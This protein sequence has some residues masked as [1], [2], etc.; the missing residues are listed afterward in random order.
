MPIEQHN[1]RER[2][3]MEKSRASL[4]YFNPLPIVEL[5]RNSMEEERM[6]ID[7]NGAQPLPENGRSNPLVT[8]SS[9]TS[10]AATSA[11]GDDQAQLS[12]TLGQV[13]GLA[14]QVSQ[15]PEVR[16][17]KVNALRQVVESG[18][19]QPSSSQVAGALFD[20]MMEAPAA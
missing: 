20:H 1:H 17:E 4:K 19:Y 5:Q 15:F 9:H 8:T 16:V 2:L 18:N 10:A 13:Q 14:A 3:G 11:F 7:G 6:R 12:A